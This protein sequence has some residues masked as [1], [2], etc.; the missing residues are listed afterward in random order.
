VVESSD[1]PPWQR[2]TRLPLEELP[3]PAE[4]LVYTLEE[5]RA[6]PQRS[7]RFAHTLEAETRWLLPLHP[8]RR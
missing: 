8:E 2:P 7:P 5:W 1:L 6:L 4:A 3:V